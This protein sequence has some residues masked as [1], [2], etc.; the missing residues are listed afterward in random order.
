M[1][2]KFLNSIMVVFFLITPIISAQV[3]SP[4]PVQTTDVLKIQQLS[5]LTLSPNG[6]HAAYVVRSIEEADQDYRYVNQIWLTNSDGSQPPRQLTFHSDGASNPSW[7]PESDRIIF[8]RNQQLFE[9][10][11]DGGEAYQL[12]D[13]DFNVSNGSSSP[14]GTQLLFSRSFSWWDMIEANDNTFPEWDFEKPGIT[15]QIFDADANP[16][17]SLDEIRAWLQRNE[18]NSNPTVLNRLSFQGEFNLNPHQSFTHWFLYDLE[19]GESIQITNGFFSFSGGTWSNDG[20]AIY[21]NG[22]TDNDLNPDRN[23][24]TFIYKY[25]VLS[26]DFSRFIEVDGYRTTNAVPSPNDN[27]LAFSAFDLSERGYNQNQ[28]GIKNLTTREISFYG[29]DIDRSFGNLKWSPN[30]QVLYAVA[31]T[32]GGFPLYAL[33]VSNGEIDRLTD[34]ETGIRDFAPTANGFLMVRT[35]IGNPFE[36]YTAPV[37]GVTFS[38]V[39][40]HNYEWLQNRVI[41]KPSKYT[42]DNDG[43][44]IEYWVMEPANRIEGE[45]YPVLLQIHGGPS[46]MWGPG[47]ASMWHE[48][49]LF[50]AHGF[51]VVY[52]NPRGSGGYGYEFQKANHQDWGDGPMR[53]VLGSLD[54]AIDSYAWMDEDQLT[55]TGGSYGGYLVAYIVAMDHRFKAAAAQRGVYDLITFLGEGNAWRLIPDRFDGY[56]WDEDILPILQRES[57]MTFAHQIETPLLILHGDNDLRTGVSQSEMLYRTLK[58]LERDVEYIRY[59][60]AGHDMSRTGNPNQRMDRQLRMIEFMKRYVH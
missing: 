55:V 42:F 59:P 28:I 5:N 22:N 52:S 43:L 1:R 2:N 25:D 40:S 31:P 53:D 20:T 12:T 41:S 56:P 49:Q 8:S 47:E 24:T 27:L 39:S 17:G 50:A 36:L 57:P 26:G 46:A 29:S 14:D 15:P 9:I 13:F 54:R 30:G 11:I 44:E 35:H 51:G 19:S 3:S 60:G 45:S 48:F 32:N 23:L 58:I 18:R 6:E 7:H 16:D 10:L 21:F 33:D 4:T 34:L 38:A 37:S